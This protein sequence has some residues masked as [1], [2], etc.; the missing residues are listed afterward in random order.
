MGIKC[1]RYCTPPKR[2]LACHDDCPEY[3]IEKKQWEEDKARARCAHNSTLY[4]SDFEMLAC[5]HKVRKYNDR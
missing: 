2:H 4:P 3:L 5:M 1:C